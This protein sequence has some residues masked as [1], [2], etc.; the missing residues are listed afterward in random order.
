MG[1]FNSVPQDRLLNAVK[2]FTTKWNLTYDTP[3][4]TIDILATGNPP[5]STTLPYKPPYTVHPDFFG[6]LVELDIEP[7]EDMHLL[8]FDVNLPQR[9]ITYIPPDAPWKICSNASA[10]SQ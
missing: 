1:F 2:S 3:T 7:V 5:F 8:G 10:G 6:N 4:L 9:T